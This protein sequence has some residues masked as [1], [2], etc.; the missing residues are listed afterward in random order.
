LAQ[1]PYLNTVKGDIIKAIAVHEKY[2]WGEIRDHLGFTNEQLRPHIKELKAEEILTEN[3]SEFRVEYNLWLAYKAHFGDEWAENKLKQIENGTEWKQVILRKIAEEKERESN[4]K[5]RVREWIKFKKVGLP[6]RTSHIFLRW[7]QLDALLRDLIPLAKEEIIIVNPYVEK[8]GLCDLF[9]LATS[10]GVNVE[11]ITRSPSK[12]FKGKRKND[13]YIYHRNMNDLGVKVYYNE[14]VHAKLF[15]LD[16]QVLI[17]SSMNLYSESIA[18]KLW[19]AGIASID[20]SNVKMALG[21]YQ[22]L[23]SDPYTQRQN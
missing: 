13:K 10:K 6:A 7:D 1:L 19:E 20:Q 15:I 16:K 5:N 17:V 22:Q 14:N 21:T 2:S 3:N 12:D 18:G 11:L 8:S 9:I 4:L 23:L